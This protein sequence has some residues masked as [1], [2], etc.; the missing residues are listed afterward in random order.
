MQSDRSFHKITVGFFDMNSKV[1]MKVRGY[2]CRR[3]S[4]TLELDYTYY[5]ERTF[6]A[7]DPLKTNSWKLQKAVYRIGTERRN[8]QKKKLAGAVSFSHIRQNILEW[9]PFRK[10]DRV[11]EIG[12]GCGA[13]RVPS[14][15]RLDPLP[16]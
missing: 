6:T 14:H 16:V 2:L 15:R 7:T 11:L 13:M 9:V 10:T 5:P 4:V 3:E 1:T 12:S 8:C